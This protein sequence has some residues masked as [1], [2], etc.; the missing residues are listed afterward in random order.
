MQKPKFEPKPM[1]DPA[2]PVVVPVLALAAVLAL[3]ACAPSPAS[4]ARDRPGRPGTPAVSPAGPASPAGAAAEAPLTGTRWTVTGLL[5]RAGATPLP[6]AARGAAYFTLTPEGSASG[7]LG[8]NR[9]SAP[10]AYAPDGSVAFGPVLATRMACTGPRGE[11][12][13]ALTALFA[14][15][16]LTVRLTDRSLQ[17]T[18]AD[19]ASGLTAATTP[20]GA[21]TAGATTAG[22]Q[23]G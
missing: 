21:T 6:A 3:L 16:P 18:A 22:A 10:V 11:V 2:R 5:G 13:R 15:G 4:P 23:P 20:D 8:C 12:E 7:N 19:G 17:L 14:T 9:F 1:R